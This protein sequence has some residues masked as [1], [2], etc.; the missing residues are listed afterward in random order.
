MLTNWPL[1]AVAIA[2]LPSLVG[3]APVTRSSDRASAPTRLAR[4]HAQL[5]SA[6][7]PADSTLTASPSRVRLVFSEPIEAK[8][9]RIVIVGP[10]P[11]TSRALLKAA[12]DPSD[13]HAV[14]A[15][16]A[17]LASGGYR[18][19]WRVVSTDG[20]PVSGSY[21]FAIAAP[22]ASPPAPPTA[23]DSARGGQNGTTI[24]PVE[25]GGL[26]GAPVLAALLRGL[27]VGSLMAFGGLLMLIAWALPPA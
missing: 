24:V 22:A 19:Q 9:S 16:V 13:V 14:I 10:G 17:R 12:A 2:V 20:H 8:L 23:G 6:E 15:T 7:P 25:P 11:D 18:V 4:P 21:V 26:W 27:G 1:R 3:S 5:V